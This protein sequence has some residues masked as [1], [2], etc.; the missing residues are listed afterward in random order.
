MRIKHSKYKNTGLI[1]ELL[2]KQIA[3]DTL[4]KK[5]SNAVEILKKYFTG[6]SALVREFKLYE[7]VLKNKSVSQSKAESIVSTI[8][9]VSRSIDKKLLKT[10][11]YNLI[12]EIKDNYNIEDFFSINVKDYKPLAALYCLMEAHKVTDIVDPNFLVD[13]KTTILEHLTR[14]RQNKKVVRDNLIEE[15]SKYDKDLK[16]LTFKILLEKFNSKYGSLLPEQKN[17]LKEFITSVNSSTKLRNIV[18]EEF[19]KIKVVIEN[20]THSIED[21]IVVIKLQEVA[22]SINPISKT[23]RVTDEHLINIMQYYELVQE[24]KGL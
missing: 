19:K 8:I 24:L 7:F 21:E 1:F 9:E 13:N 6:K 5:D 2:V 14:E 16:L 12:R 18:N 11:K 20:L 23:K 17:I 10:Q 3:A 15:Y 22:K 4:D